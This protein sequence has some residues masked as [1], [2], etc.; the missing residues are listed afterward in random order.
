MMMEQAT[1]VDT[2]PDRVAAWATGTGV[3]VF[4]FMMVWLVGNRLTELFVPQPWAAV[5]AM[6]SAVATGVVVSLRQ[7]RR[8]AAKVMVATEDR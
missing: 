8:L 7:G 3:G 1:A 5:V 4:A 6:A 2:R